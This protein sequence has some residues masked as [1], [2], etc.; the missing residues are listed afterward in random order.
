MNSTIE[1]NVDDSSTTA[2]AM[3]PE[4]GYVAIDQFVD[5][6]TQKTPL[7]S[8]AREMSLVIAAIVL[9][10][11]LRLFAGLHAGLEVD[12]PIYR[13]AA[14]Y[15]AHYGFP[16][17]RAVVNQPTIPF[18]YHPPFFL[19]LLAGWFKLW[20]STS[21]L[22]GRMLN[23]LISVAIL[24]TLYA[25]VRN[26]IGKTTALLTILLVG[27]DAWLVFTNQAIYFENSQML[28][29]ILAIWAYWWATQ[30]DKTQTRSYT[31]RYLL[32]GVLVG[33]VLVYK[34]IGGYLLISILLGLLLQ[35]KH[36]RGH[37]LLLLAMCSV[38]AAY[39]IGMH[40]TFGN[41]FDSATITQ[42]ARTLWSRKSPGLSYGP[43]TALQIII[44]RYWIF[45]LTIFT[46]VGGSAL[47]A[48]RFLQHL[49][50]KKKEAHPVLLAWAL[51][52]VIFAL[53]ISLKSPHYMILWLVPLYTY[54]S[55]ECSP[56]LQKG[57]QRVKRR[58]AQSLQTPQ[59][60]LHAWYTRPILWRVILI[61]VLLVNVWSFQARFLHIPGD[62]LI[63]SEDYMNTYLPVNALVVTQDFI[64]VDIIPN[65]VN[66]AYIDTPT[67]IF[68][69]GA[70]YAAFYWSTTEPLPTSFGNTN[71]YCT[72]IKTFTGFKDH[73][74]L[75]KLNTTALATML[76]KHTGT[77][78]N[79]IYGASIHHGLLLR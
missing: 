34:Q 62:P 37:A 67:K 28:F 65:Y 22:T 39:V 31:S 18:L 44:N 42:I 12:E 30:A 5:K 48:I 61:L 2:M 45:P 6:H 32:A 68:Q 58:H 50:K 27:S 36:W 38:I 41:L 56:L 57:L 49:F 23:I 43:S 25:F 79:V 71:T 20:G 76:T 54:L 60:T 78:T 74:E 77:M 46:L 24:T 7:F 59:P 16:A 63:Q 55:K 4:H 72:P 64:A 13:Y 69:S 14:A 3:L 40:L 70:T 11:G 52:G 19:W 51:G 15:A 53:S 73:V 10:F 35:R 17:V 33:W 8:K 9:A 29:I 66:I 75:C 47:V 26:T 21:Y 1:K